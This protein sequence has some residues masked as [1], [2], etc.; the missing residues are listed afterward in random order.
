MHIV[1]AAVAGAEAQRERL[2]ASPLVVTDANRPTLTLGRG[3]LGTLGIQVATLGG[4]AIP[5]GPAGVHR[6]RRLDRFHLT[7]PRHLMITLDRAHLRDLGYP[8]HLDHARLDFHR[9]I[10]PVAGRTHARFV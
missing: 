5:V 1:A 2:G 9:V 6:H 3:A 7:D 10:D 8:L 4:G